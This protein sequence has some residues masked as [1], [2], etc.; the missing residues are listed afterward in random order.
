[1]KKKLF[2]VLDENDN[3]VATE[4]YLKWSEFFSSINNRSFG[5][6]QLEGNVTV[7]TIFM[8]IDYSFGLVEK[9]PILFETMV[10]G[11]P[12]NGKIK[13]Y[14]SKD[15]AK[16]GHAAIVEEIRNHEEEE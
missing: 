12:L 6:T 9:N 11:G 2:Y 5:Y 13:R 1:M 8:G 4:D 7:S 15:D 14:S 10:F 16:K 3:P